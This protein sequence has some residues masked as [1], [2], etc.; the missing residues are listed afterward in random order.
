MAD[1]VK[2]KTSLIVGGIVT[3][4]FPDID[5]NYVENVNMDIEL[6]LVHGPGGPVMRPKTPPRF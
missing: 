4:T 1:K 2:I 5:I 3:K 6:E